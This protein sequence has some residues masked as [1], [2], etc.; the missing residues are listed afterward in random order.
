MGALGKDACVHRNSENFWER[1]ANIIINGKY[2]SYFFVCAQVIDLL[3][4]VE[5][6]TRASVHAL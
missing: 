6:K 2:R 3:R 4:C 5:L 1:Y